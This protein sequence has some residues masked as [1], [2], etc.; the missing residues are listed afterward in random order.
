MDKHNIVLITIDTLRR[1]HCGC[2]GY[3]RDTTPFLDELTEDGVKFSNV[4]SN[5]PLTTRSFPAI[6]CGVEGPAFY[7]LE[8]DSEIFHLPRHC[9][10][11]AERMR[12]RGYHTVAF[13][14]GNPYLSSFYGYDRG[15]DVFHDYLD[16][17]SGGKSLE[18]TLVKK[19]VRRVIKGNRFLNSLW[20]KSKSAVDYLV[21]FSQ[22]I[23]SKTP[24]V[25]GR[26]LNDDVRAWLQ[27]S[28]PDKPLFLW[29]HYM[30]VHQP[31][32]P[33]ESARRELGV[34]KYSSGKLA[35]HWVDMNNHILRSDQQVAELI[36]LYDCEIRYTDK[37]LKDLFTILG[38][39]GINHTNSS[40]IITSDHGDEFGEHGS[41]GHVLKPYNE[42]LEVPFVISGKNAGLFE[43]LSDSLTDLKAITSMISG[44]VDGISPSIEREYVISE[45]RREKADYSGYIRLISIQNK[46]FKLI[47]DFGDKSKT[48]FYSLKEDP[49]EKENI[50]NKKIFLKKMNELNSILRNYI[51]TQQKITTEKQLIKKAID[52]L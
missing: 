45:S 43:P 29:V 15:F 22:V 12:E 40:F 38:E 46:S 18:F 52:K 30:D 51:E 14:A 26:V 28:R 4:L 17:G 11:L 10:S 23:R 35:R 32:I 41:L 9:K 3:G 34:P 27:S 50:L 48:E 44:L 25:R 16:L 20:M 21:A 7:G 8:S 36:D 39:H 5:G 2:Y 49:T 6:F 31:H 24:F 47:H 33:V 19:A 37:C 13:Q 1:D 42:M